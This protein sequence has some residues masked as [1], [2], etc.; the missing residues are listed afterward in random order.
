MPTNCSAEWVS[1]SK[2]LGMT[3]R[4]TSNEPAWEFPNG[5][6]GSGYTPLDAFVFLDGR[7]SPCLENLP[8]GMRSRSRIDNLRVSALFQMAA[9]LK[10][11]QVTS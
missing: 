6:T 11:G 1:Y 7:V 9:M 4:R 5:S 2:V 10:L 8:P 3:R